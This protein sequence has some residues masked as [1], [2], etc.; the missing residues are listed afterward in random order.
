MQTFKI[1]I[2]DETKNLGFIHSRYIL[3]DQCIQA[4]KATTGVEGI[5]PGRYN[6]VV[7]KGVLH[8]WEEVV[9][10][11]TQVAIELRLLAVEAAEEKEAT[12]TP[13]PK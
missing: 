3:T 11:L 5:L 4:F 7:F 13:C 6:C 10:N 2:P 1:S 8:T 9:T 12:P